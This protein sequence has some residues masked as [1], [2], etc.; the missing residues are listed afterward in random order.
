MEILGDKGK[1]TTIIGIILLIIII[2]VFVLKYMG[3]LDEGVS[4]VMISL[5]GLLTAVGFLLTKDSDKSHTQE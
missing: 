3:K 4:E 5:T 2:A 1:K